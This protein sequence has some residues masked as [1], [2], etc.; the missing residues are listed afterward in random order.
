M[1]V[2]LM[3]L[4]CMIMYGIFDYLIAGPARSIKTLH[5]IFIFSWINTVILWVLFFVSWVSLELSWNIIYPILGG[6]TGHLWVYFYSKSVTT[7]KIWISSSIANAYPIITVLVWY[8]FLKEYFTFIQWIFFVLV[9]IGI[10]FSSFH[11]KELRSFSFE[12]NKKSLSYAFWAM[13][14][15]ASFGFFFDYSM[16]F[17]S[18]IASGVLVELSVFLLVG[19][20]LLTTQK[21]K[22]QE[23]SYVSKK[24]FQQILVLSIVWNI[25]FIMLGYAFSI[26]SLALVSAIAACSPAITTL[27]ARVYWKE[28]LETV[29]YLAIS[30][31][32][33]WIAGLS[34]VSV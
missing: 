9:L 15:W 27:L 17:F 3:S 16:N 24:I 33:F 29:Q 21:L 10:I 13:I 2:I 7:G 28:K 8:I 12:K 23:F 19:S 31:L 20:F 26:G 18:P 6:I 14:M 1:N 34:Y 4:I 11:F 32:V 22:L 30:L 25:G 5:L